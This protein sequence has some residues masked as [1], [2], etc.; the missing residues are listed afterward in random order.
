[1]ILAQDA[2]ASPGDPLKDI[3][4]SFASSPTVAMTITDSAG[5]PVSL[6]TVGSTVNGT[7]TVLG[8]FNPM[9]TLTVNLYSNGSCS[10][11]ATARSPRSYNSSH[12]NTANSVIVTVNSTGL[13]SFNATYSG[14]ANNNLAISAC[15]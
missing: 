8:G 15:T 9:G 4:A 14:D 13:Y 7:A 3:N 5:V 1:S 12:S 2:Q 11:D 6:A 10:G